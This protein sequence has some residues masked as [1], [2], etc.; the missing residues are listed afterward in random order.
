[1][2]FLFAMKAQSILGPP[3]NPICLVDHSYMLGFCHNGKNVPVPLPKPIHLNSKYR[4]FRN[5]MGCEVFQISFLLLLFHGKCLGTKFF[6][7]EVRGL[8]KK[9]NI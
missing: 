6:L 8:V 3:P 2:N 1:M 9:L 4:E 5:W 7:E